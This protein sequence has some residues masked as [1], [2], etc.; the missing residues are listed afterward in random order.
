MSSETRRVKILRSIGVR[1]RQ[2]RESA[3]K[4]SVGEYKDTRIQ[5]MTGLATN[6]CL[7]IGKTPF[8]LAWMK[9]Q[10]HTTNCKDSFRARGLSL[11]DQRRFLADGCLDEWQR[12]R[13]ALRKNSV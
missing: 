5:A 4:I 13:E 7:L 10:L 9:K 2:E 11:M 1:V 3:H 8:G 6:P 12:R